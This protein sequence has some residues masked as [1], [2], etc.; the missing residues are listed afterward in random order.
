[1][2]EGRTLSGDHEDDVTALV[3]MAMRS[4]DVPGIASA[5]RESLGA[6]K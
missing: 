1:M 5:I 3:G 6:E 4:L 2:T